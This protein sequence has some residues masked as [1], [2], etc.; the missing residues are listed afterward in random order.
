MKFCDKTYENGSY[1]HIQ[2]VIRQ[3]WSVWV[4]RDDRLRYLG[5]AKMKNG[6][7]KKC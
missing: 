4:V 3:G 5:R 6:E 7:V 1:L 2:S